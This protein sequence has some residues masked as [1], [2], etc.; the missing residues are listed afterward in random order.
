MA[1]QASRVG[2]NTF[3]ANACEECAERGIAGIA[4]RL[5]VPLS[6]ASSKACLLQTRTMLVCLGVETRIQK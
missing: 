5:S 3:A 2:A 4:E 1:S 6:H